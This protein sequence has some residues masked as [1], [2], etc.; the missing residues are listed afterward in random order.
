MLF[1]ACLLIVCV[2]SNNNQGYCRYFRLDFKLFLLL[3]SGGLW[4]VGWARISGQA[5]GGLNSI[6]PCLNPEVEKSAGWV[7]F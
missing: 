7:P 3:D 5:E 1:K 6:P 2:V 4:E